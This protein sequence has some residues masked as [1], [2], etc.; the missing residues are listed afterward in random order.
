[1]YLRL[2]VFR[3]FQDSLEGPDFTAAAAAAAAAAAGVDDEEEQ[4]VERSCSYSEGKVSDIALACVTGDTS[5][6]RQTPD[7]R[8]TERSVLL[9]MFFGCFFGEHSMHS[10]LTTVLLWSIYNRPRE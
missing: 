1:M 10:M 5:S 2:C 8:T 6:S 7:R 3:R 9:L 4:R